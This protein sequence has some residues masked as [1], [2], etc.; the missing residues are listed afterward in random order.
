MNVGRDATMTRVSRL[1][2]RVVG[3]PSIALAIFAAVVLWT[4]MLLRHGYVFER[5]PAFDASLHADTAW[6]L[7]G[8]S[9]LGGI[10]NIGSQ[11]VFFQPFAAV[12]WLISHL[13]FH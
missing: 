10:S 4:P 9:L 6:S 3:H 5:D 1:R 13:E 2:I 8:F 7:G 12:I 11:G